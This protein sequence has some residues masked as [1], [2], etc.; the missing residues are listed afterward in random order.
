MNSTN[1]KNGD[2]FGRS[3]AIIIVLLSTFCFQ[4]KSFVVGSNSA[5]SRHRQCCAVSGDCKTN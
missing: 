4:A 2:Y 3:V 1:I 5:P